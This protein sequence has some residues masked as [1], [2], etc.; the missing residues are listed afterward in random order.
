MPDPPLARLP[1]PNRSIT[2]ETERDFNALSRKFSRIRLRG[3]A[4]GVDTNVAAKIEG[5]TSS[6]TAGAAEPRKLRQAPR[7]DGAASSKRL[8]ART[9]A[10]SLD[11]RPPVTGSC[12]ESRNGPVRLSDYRA[13]EFLIDTVHLDI[14]LA[15]RTDHACGRVCDL[16]PKALRPGPLALAGDELKLD[17]LAARRPTAARHGL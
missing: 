1:F 5:R 13:P 11:R 2:H 10:T 3:N 17:S 12:N 7:V 16:R 8:E 4:P 14:H 15:P 6:T 9:D